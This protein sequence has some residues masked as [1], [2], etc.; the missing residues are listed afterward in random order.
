MVF[1]VITYTPQRM[2]IFGPIPEQITLSEV[3][4][5]SVEEIASGLTVPI[6]GYSLIANQ[7]DL[8]VVKSRIVN[9]VSQIPTEVVARVD[10]ETEP[11]PISEP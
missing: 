10:P 2:G 4:A 8:T 1:T 3:N 7:E 5:E 11:S 6:D 9:E